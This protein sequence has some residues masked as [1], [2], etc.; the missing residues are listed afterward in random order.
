MAWRC[1]GEIFEVFWIVPRVV[2]G[3]I[4]LVWDLLF[5]GVADRNGP[6]LHL[7]GYHDGLRQSDGRDYDLHLQREHGDENKFFVSIID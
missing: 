1:L 3:W 6:I 7:N 5:P 2:R 4:L